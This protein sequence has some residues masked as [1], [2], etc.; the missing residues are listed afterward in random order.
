MR[1]TGA[2]VVNSVETTAC[3]N[4]IANVTLSNKL[5][6]NVLW[7]K[8]Y[9][10]LDYG[11]FGSKDFITGDLSFDLAV[12]YSL[13]ADGELNGDETKITVELQFL[14]GIIVT[15]A[16]S[17]DIFMTKNGTGPFSVPWNPNEDESHTA[18]TVVVSL[19]ST[20]ITIDYPMVALDNIAFDHAK[21]DGDDQTT[22]T[23]PATTARGNV[24]SD[25]SPSQTLSP[26]IT[27]A[28]FGSN[29]TSGT[30]IIHSP[31]LTAEAPTS[32]STGLAPICSPTLFGVV[33]ALAA[34]VAFL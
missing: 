12:D 9:I 21:V 26:T 23:I 17:F 19:W 18:F 1:I 29:I 33:A 6:N 5:E 31:T 13:L 30:S 22:S 14:N 28:P 24:T 25:S 11:A 10:K 27:S 34:G 3:N 7:G 2:S 15:Q 32:T 16:T 20:S 8:E 4:P